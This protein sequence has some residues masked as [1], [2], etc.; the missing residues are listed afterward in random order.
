MRG[1]MPSTRKNP[2]ETRW[3][4][5]PSSGASDAQHA[6]EPGRD[7]LL[8]DVLDPASRRKVDAHRTIAKQ[9]GVQIGGIGAH[10]LPNAAPK[11]RL[12]GLGA[13]ALEIPGDREQPLRMG[14]R[15]R[16]Q[17]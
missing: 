16:A 10:R 13:F 17:Q 3:A 8:L 12:V 5:L 14:I 1:A 4:S 7:T 11:I 9:G 6:K 15:Q 2:A